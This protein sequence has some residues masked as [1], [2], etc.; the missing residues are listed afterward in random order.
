MAR[1]SM[2][3]SGLNE[4]M[5]KFERMGGNVNDAAAAALEKTHGIVTDRVEAAEAASRYNVVPGVTGA[6]DAS[7]RRSPEVEWSG[8]VA[9]VGVGWSIRNGGLASVFLMYGTPTI[10]PDPGLHNAI[11]GAATRRQVGEAQADV[12]AE[13]VATGDVR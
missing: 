3:F 11:F 7:V 1:M 9:S 2:E 4:L 6:T 12:L 13:L 8:P 5:A 10:A